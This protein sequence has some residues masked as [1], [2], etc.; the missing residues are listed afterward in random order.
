MHAWTEGSQSIETAF[1][2]TRQGRETVHSPLASPLF[3]RLNFYICDTIKGNESSISI[4]NFLHPFLITSKCFFWCLSMDITGHTS[5]EEYVLFLQLS[6]KQCLRLRHLTHSSWL[7]HIYCC[8]KL[9]LSLLFMHQYQYFAILPAFQQ[10]STTKTGN[11]LKYEMT[12]RNKEQVQ[13][14]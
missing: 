11:V 3:L 2:A 9:L 5:Y 12:I 7:C 6:Q 10:F 14:N 13:S 4:P 1:I 8:L